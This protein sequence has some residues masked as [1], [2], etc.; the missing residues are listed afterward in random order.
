MLWVSARV[1]VLF[2]VV[3]VLRLHPTIAVLTILFIWYDNL[4]WKVLRQWSK[5][6]HRQVFKSHIKVFYL[7]DR[8]GFNA[9]LS[10]RKRLPENN[11][12]TEAALSGDGVGSETARGGG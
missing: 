11:D 12:E 8:L 9:G 10:V 5:N 6:N 3:Q 7:T 4:P 1:S 2:H